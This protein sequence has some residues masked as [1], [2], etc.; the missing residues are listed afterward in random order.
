MLSQQLKNCL[1][2]FHMLL[3]EFAEDLDIIQV[4]QNMLAKASSENSIH[5]ILEGC[6]R[7][8]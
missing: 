8:G 2:V 5:D 6:R 4:N 1:H 7:I 3:M